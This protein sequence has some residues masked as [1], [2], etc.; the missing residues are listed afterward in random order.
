MK[1]C[2]QSIV[3]SGLGWL[4]VSAVLLIAVCFPTEAPAEQPSDSAVAGL[5]GSSRLQLGW[6]ASVAFVEFWNDGRPGIFAATTSGGEHAYAHCEGGVCTIGQAEQVI[7]ECIYRYR[8]PALDCAIVVFGR[9]VVWRGEVSSPYGRL[10]VL[11][12]HNRSLVQALV[13]EFPG[14][15]AAAA[16][17][18][19]DRAHPIGQFTIEQDAMGGYCLGIY[20][21]LADDNRVWDLRCLNGYEA[22]GTFP[23]GDLARGGAGTGTGSDGAEVRL[24]LQPR[25]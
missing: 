16:T 9:K 4:R 24:T 10:H 17:V 11:E 21:F 3:W 8:I 2:R 5:A 14:Q 22:S 19:I 23:P 1:I 15:E 13:F 18:F 25:G 12:D 6:E 7:E 20:D